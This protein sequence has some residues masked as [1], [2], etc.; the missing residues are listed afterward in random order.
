MKGVGGK[1]IGKANAYEEGKG[2]GKGKW[3]WL[4]DRNMKGGGGKGI[5]KANAYWEGERNWLWRGEGIWKLDE[6]REFEND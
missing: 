4:G 3:L 5:G 1:G 6:G 2:I